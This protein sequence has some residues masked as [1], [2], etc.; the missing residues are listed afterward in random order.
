MLNGVFVE[1]NESAKNENESAMSKN[2]S[3]TKNEIFCGV[4]IY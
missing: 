1:N 3:V 2:E 4:F